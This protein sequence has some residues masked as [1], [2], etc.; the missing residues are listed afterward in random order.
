[1]L[2]NRY[3]QGMK[4]DLA[5]NLRDIHR[6]FISESKDDGLTWSPAKPVLTIR[7]NNSSVGVLK[8]PYG[9]TNGNY[10]G[11]G[12]GLQLRSA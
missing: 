9:T 12:I 4:Y 1:M 5:K 6:Q 7:N 11:G 2:T 8:L 3:F 10:A